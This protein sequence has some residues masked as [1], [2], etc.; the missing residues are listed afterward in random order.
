LV[1]RPTERRNRSETDRERRQP[2]AGVSDLFPGLTNAD[3]L[4]G[5]TPATV[6]PVDDTQLRVTTLPAGAAKTVSVI[7]VT[8]TGHSASTPN[9]QFTYL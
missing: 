1:C 7:A 2:T 9:A 4:F 8:T 3:I 5:T 6:T